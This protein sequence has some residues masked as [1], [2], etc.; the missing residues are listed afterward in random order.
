MKE[1]G[2][3]EVKEVEVVVLWWWR[4]RKRWWW[5][6]RVFLRL[7]CCKFCFVGPDQLKFNIS[8][9]RHSTVTITS[10]S[11]NMSLIYNICFIGVIDCHF[12]HV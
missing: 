4:L 2:E 6:V 1:E 10:F 3:D 12:W 11:L 8:R 9:I 7:C 5:N